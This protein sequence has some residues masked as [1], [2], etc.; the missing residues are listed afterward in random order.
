MKKKEENKFYVYAYLDPRKPGN[1][2]YGEF[3]FNYEPFYIGKGFENRMYKHLD[4]SVINKN[5]NKHKVSKIKNIIKEFGDKPII[6][7]LVKELSDKNALL[8]EKLY[9]KKIG[10]S[11]LKSGP[12]TNLTNGGD[13]A[14]GK[15]CSNETKEKIRAHNV[16]KKLSDL[17]RKKMSKSRSDGNIWNKNKKGKDSHL[18]GIKRSEETKIKISKSKL[19]KKNPMFGKPVSTETRLK[20][21][22]SIKGKNIKYYKITNPT[23]EV[24][25]TKLGLGDFCISN[26]LCRTSMVNVASGKRKNY[27]N[28]KCEHSTNHIHHKI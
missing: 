5:T 10:R 23:G 9:I 3:K 21:R 16:G 8:I 11:D 25:Y 2:I 19:G 7:K 18:Y 1:Y 14:S 22:E 12:L 27:K 6:I 24:F 15:I 17:T 26:K 4:E 20:K 28:W 13:G